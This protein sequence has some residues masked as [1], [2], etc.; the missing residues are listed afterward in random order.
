MKKIILLLLSISVNAQTTKIISR[1]WTAFTQT[2]SIESKTKK[3]FKVEASVKVI[4]QDKNA[5]AGLWARVDTKNEEDGFFDNMSDRPIKSDT[6]QSYVIEG[7]I[8]SNSKSLNFGGICQYN[9]Q[10]YFDHFKLYIENDKGILEFV[11]MYN[12][13]FEEKVKSGLIPKWSQGISKDKI[14][15]VKE[16]QITSSEDKVEGKYALLLEGKGIKSKDKGKI[17]KVEGASPQIGAMIAMLENLKDRVES[18]VKNMS[19]YELDYLHDDKANRIG[20]LIMHLAAAEAYYQVYTFENRE[21]NEEEKKKWQVALDL[22]QGGRD[23]FKGHDAQY[24]LDIYN[25]VRAKT[26]TELKK[27]DDAWFEEVHKENGWNNH[28]CWFHV[29]EHQSSHL[30]QI[31]FLSKRIPPQPELKLNQTIRN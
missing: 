15:S 26:I 5:G 18:K 10:F 20:S 4:T 19:Q 28:F 27:R 24:Y 7:T 2:L 1:D 30:G 11:E 29:M 13:S 16:Y 17:T 14:I 12:S 8:D 9:G 25:E 6:W 23:D 21:F 3:K 31:L 22:D